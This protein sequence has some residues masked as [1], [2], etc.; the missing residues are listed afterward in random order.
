MNTLPSLTIVMPVL[1]EE[2]N[3]SAAIK[4]AL[5]ALDCHKIEGELIVVNDGS[6]DQSEKIV[7]DLMKNHPRIKLI[8]H[9]RPLGIGASFW[10]GVRQAKNEYVTCFPGDNEND[11]LD[12]LTY[13]HLAQKVDVIIPFIHNVEVRS[14]WRRTVS[15][16]YRFIIN[17]SF[18]T[19]L[20]YTNGTIIYNRSILSNLKP[21]S[22]GFIYQAEI[23]IRLIRE[24]YLYAETPNFLKTRNFGKSKALYF[25]SI[26]M[27]IID[28]IRLFW[29]IHIVRTHG[30]MKNPS[31]LHP[32]SMTLER[33][34]GRGVMV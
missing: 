5:Y 4:S 19:N 24:G 8:N 2:R 33:V 26:S 11:A 32:K 7:C 10:D 27:V 25:K 31:S 30:R 23:L 34:K 22:S 6:S 1:N 16:C 29:C 18:G 13:Y 21:I 28:F 3:V 12:A 14:Y 20:N 17:L 9:K 15:A